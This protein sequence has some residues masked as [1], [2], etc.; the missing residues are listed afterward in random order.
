MASPTLYCRA[1]IGFRQAI[2]PQLHMALELRKW[3]TEALRLSV[4][5]VCPLAPMSI[6]VIASLYV[7]LISGLP[8]GPPVKVL[9]YSSLYF[10][11]PFSDVLH[12]DAR[13]SSPKCLH[14]RHG[15]M[16][17][18]N[19]RSDEQKVYFFS[20]SKTE[21]KKVGTTVITSPCSPPIPLT[22]LAVEQKWQ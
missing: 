4:Y 12:R 10:K 20:C 6:S 22:D 8:V 15:R 17:V 19:N 3:L 9:H 1:S 16:M 5:T 14:C 13:L 18:S 11:L 21:R 2:S 7:G